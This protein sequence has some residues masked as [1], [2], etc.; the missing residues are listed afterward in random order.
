MD[1]GVGA[2]ST[3]ARKQKQGRTRLDGAGQQAARQVKLGGA[4]PLLPQRAAGLGGGGLVW[5]WRV[6]K[7]EVGL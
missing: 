5:G 6:C 1:V 7:R 2:G 3:T 4:E